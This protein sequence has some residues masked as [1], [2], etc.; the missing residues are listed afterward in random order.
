MNKMQMIESKGGELVIIDYDNNIVTHPVF[1]VDAI[2][3]PRYG[4]I[5]VKED[6]SYGYL[7]YG[8]QLL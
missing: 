8:G 7:N 6:G 2:G 3:Y 1:N 4:F 5:Q